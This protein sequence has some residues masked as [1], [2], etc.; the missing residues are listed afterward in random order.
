MV[1]LVDQINHG[2][3]PGVAA[4]MM[5]SA[6]MLRGMPCMM[7][8]TVRGLVKSVRAGASLRGAP[9]EGGDHAGVD[10]RGVCALRRAFHDAEGR[11]GSEAFPDNGD[12]SLSL[13]KG[14][15]R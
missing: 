11:R 8:E 13:E 7:L 10:E 12:E 3:T 4:L 15:W 6:P 1:I 2:M 5:V 14:C 9:N